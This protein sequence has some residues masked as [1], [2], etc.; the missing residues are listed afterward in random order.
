MT[1]Q[2]TILG[3]SSRVF[4]ADF[5]E[6]TEKVCDVYGISQQLLVSKNRSFR[7]CEA[8]NEAVWHLLQLGHS[9]TAI[10]RAFNRDHSTVIHA[11]KRHQKRVEEESRFSAYR[12]TSARSPVVAVK[13]EGFSHG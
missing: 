4:E 1:H 8:R 9:Y 7:V 2:T 10:G 6:I 5:E 11:E 12:F 13:S 3:P